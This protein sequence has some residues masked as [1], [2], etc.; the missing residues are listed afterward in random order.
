MSPNV[1]R[2]SLQRSVS[3]MRFLILS[4]VLDNSQMF[5]FSYFTQDEVFVSSIHV[6]MVVLVVKVTKDLF[7]IVQR[8]SVVPHVQVSNITNIYIN[9]CL[10]FL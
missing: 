6:E 10:I 3:F 9:L 1:S 5:S 7:V 4:I 2:G 8:D